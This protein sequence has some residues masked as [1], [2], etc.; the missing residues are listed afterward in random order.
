MMGIRAPR[1][2]QTISEKTGANDGRPRIGT[3]EWVGRDTVESCR[4]LDVNRLHARAVCAPAGRVAGNG[5]ATARRSLGS[6]CGPRPTG[7]ISPI[8]CASPV[9][10]GR[11]CRD[12][13]HRPCRLPLRWVAALFHLSRLV[14]G[15][16]CGRRVAK[17]HGPGRY[18]L[19]RHCYRLGH[20]SQGE[21]TWDRALRCAN[22]IRQ[23][24][25]GDPVWL[26]LSAKAERHVEADL[27]PPARASLR[28]RDAGRRSLRDPSRTAAVGDRQP[29]RRRRSNQ[30]RS[31]WR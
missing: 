4:S 27:R 14:N 11:T 6:I 1:T 5:R 20:A 22:K 31:Y 16:A 2:C 13:P 26:R 21:D 25:G 15:V 12:R 24:L 8:A 23:R 10:T 28:D 19:C 29:P 9:A 18:F 3:A 17:L 30:K 7:C